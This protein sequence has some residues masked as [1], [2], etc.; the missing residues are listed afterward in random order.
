MGGKGVGGFVGMLKCNFG[1]SLQCRVSGIVRELEC[2]WVTVEAKEVFWNCQSYMRRTVLVGWNMGAG[3]GARWEA[4]EVLTEG[5]GRLIAGSD[6]RFLRTLYAGIGADVSF[7]GGVFC[8]SYV[9][10]RIVLAGL[11]CFNQSGI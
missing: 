11:G 5:D 1:R 4:G 10:E 3:G 8:K 7:R 2:R 9:R 6:S